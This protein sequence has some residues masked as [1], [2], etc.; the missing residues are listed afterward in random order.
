MPFQNRVTPWGEIVALPG[1]G[2]LTGNRGVLHDDCKRI[3]RQFA[4]KRWIACRL[5]Y[6][7]IRRAIMT[8]HRWTELFFL[9][10]ATAFAAGHRP[11]AECRRED[12]KRFR[13]LWE[14]RFGAVSSVD[15]IDAILHDQ[16][17]QTGRKPV[18]RAR[19]ESLHDG[20]YVQMNDAAYVLWNGELARWSDSGY[21]ERLQLPAIELDVLTPRSIVEL[22]R[23]GYR[24]AIHPTLHLRES[25]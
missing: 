18:W 14:S 11:C 12:Y 21:R 20:T 2:L 23:A 13:S 9:D 24:P 3:V 10:E 15:E 5:E 1:R 7:G 16:R 8:P 17:L 22:F 19:V 6:K 25:A 4:V